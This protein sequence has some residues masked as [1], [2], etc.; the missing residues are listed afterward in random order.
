MESNQ[1]IYSTQICVFPWRVWLFR[2]LERGHAHSRRNLDQ[3]E[4]M[5]R[6][7]GLILVTDFFSCFAARSLFDVRF[8]LPPS[9][10][11]LLL[12]QQRDER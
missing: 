12:T 9:D 4:G 11:F 10:R 5:D 2:D 3:V 6:R 1:H 7:G 8:D